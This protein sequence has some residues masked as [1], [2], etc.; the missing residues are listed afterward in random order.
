MSDFL[1]LFSAKLKDAAKKPNMLAYRPNSETHANFHKSDKVGRILRGGNRSGKSVAGVVETA[2]RATGRHP[3]QKTHELPI[4]ARI[5]TVDRDAG[6]KQIILPLLQQWIPPSEL[7]NGNWTDSWNQSDKVLRLR[8]GSEIEIKTHQQEVE[9]FA[10]VPRHFIWFDEECP[11]AIFNECR[12]RLIDYDGSWIMTM[13]PVEGMDWIYDRFIVTKAKNVA[14]FEVD[15]TDNPHLNKRAL[16]LLDDDLDDEEKQIRRQGLF[17]PKGGLVINQFDHGRHIIAGGRDIPS[18]WTVYM[19][20]DHG[21]NNPTAVLWHAV[22][23]RGEVVTFKEHYQRLLTVNQHAK[24][25]KEMEKK[26]DRTPSIRMCDPAM[27]QR[28][29]ETGTSA[30]KLYRDNGINLVPAGR[31]VQGRLNK[32]NEYLENDM[33]HITQDC[34][35]TLKEIRSYS[36][37]IY[38]TAK[39]ADRSNK[40]EEP[41]KKNDHAMDACGYFFNFMPYL[42]SDQ[43]LSARPAISKTITNPVDFP[44]EVDSHFFGSEPSTEYAFGEYE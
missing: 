27:K 43:K 6:M 28:T 5:V 4:K 44:W 7:K 13:T 23:P 11:Q 1:E 19:S 38:H 31:D 3:Y 40:R 17:V 36:Y 25:I 24:I 18:N 14:M 42:R 41:N 32:M 2:W 21:Y 29:A 16:E 8:N 15:I 20:M 26:M 9:S 10:G 37:K 39:I 30:F 33:W 12:L 22:S 34:P 35:N